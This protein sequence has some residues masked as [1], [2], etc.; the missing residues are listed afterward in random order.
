MDKVHFFL[1]FSLSRCNF[2]SVAGEDFDLDLRLKNI[3][4]GTYVRLLC[5]SYI[6]LPTNLSFSTFILKLG[7]CLHISCIG[8]N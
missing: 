3:D 6:F 8:Q 4:F 7:V 5:Y 2:P 1:D